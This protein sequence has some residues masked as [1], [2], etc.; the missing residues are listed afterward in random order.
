M[1]QAVIPLLPDAIALLV[2]EQKAEGLEELRLRVGQPVQLRYGAREVEL[3]KKAEPAD[4]EEVLRR[5]C[6]QSVY[7]C[8]DTLKEGY[9]TVEGGH[10][11]GVCG[12]GVLR[13]GQVQTLR[14]PGSLSIRI[15]RQVPGCA[16]GLAPLLH[17]SALILGPP[18][19][20]KTTLLRDAIVLLSD[21][22]KKRVGLVDERGEIAASV[23]GVPQLYVGRRTDVLV[24][25]GKAEG[26][27]MLLRTMNPQWI[28]VDEITS[29]ADIQAMVQAS[30]CGIH[31][32]ATAHGNDRGDLTG[33]PLYRSLME[34]GVFR[35]VV[36]LHE[37]RH[38]ECFEVSG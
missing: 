35:R 4:L 16:D 9:L 18:G 5:A 6:R 2:A 34:T 24:N 19:S 27:M 12:T 28:A 14:A 25:V 26:I 31:L 36:V 38:F 20:G 1:K 33:R 17:C 23:G 30:Y 11:I 8:S 3:G 29:P 21:K 15:A 32:L 37:D 22:Q 13:E 10:R 7:A